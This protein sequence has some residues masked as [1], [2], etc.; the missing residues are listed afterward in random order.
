MRKLDFFCSIG[1]LQLWG[2]TIQVDWAEPEKDVDDE[3]MQ[4]VKVLYVSAQPVTEH[5]SPKN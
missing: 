5:S 1:S 3:V 2:H 4:R